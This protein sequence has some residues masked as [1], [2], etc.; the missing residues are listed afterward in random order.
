VVSILAVLRKIRFAHIL[1]SMVRPYFIFVFVLLKIGMLGRMLKP[2][3]NHYFKKILIKQ[4]YMTSFDIVYIQ[5]R[6]THISMVS[7]AGL[8]SIWLCKECR[9]N[10]LFYSDVEEHKERTGHYMIQEYEMSSGK[11]LNGIDV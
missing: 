5:Y 11:L 9:A 3:N 6:Y 8:N 1:N 2:Y 4:K 10:F 7:A